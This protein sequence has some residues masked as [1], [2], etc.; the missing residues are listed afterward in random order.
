M[1]R[2]I[3]QND[4]LRATGP[5]FG[6]YPL[7]DKVDVQ[8]YPINKRLL[9]QNPKVDIILYYPDRKKYEHLKTIR[10]Q[11]LVKDEWYF[12]VVKKYVTANRPKKYFTVRIVFPWKGKTWY[13]ESEGIQMVYI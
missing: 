3:W 1:S 11:T 4:I 6:N 8:V 5:S 2:P 7:G 12:R 9:K 10:L 13:T